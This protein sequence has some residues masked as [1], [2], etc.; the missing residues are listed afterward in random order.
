MVQLL[1]AGDIDRFELCDQPELST[2][3]PC[4]SALL[5]KRESFM[6]C[7]EGPKPSTGS[8]L[9]GRQSL[10][11]TC[12]P[13]SV[14]FWY[15]WV[16]G[17]IL[18]FPVTRCRN[19]WCQTVPGETDWEILFGFP[20]TS[21][22]WWL[23]LSVIYFFLIIYALEVILLQCRNRH[24]GKTSIPK[25]VP[26]GSDAHTHTHSCMYIYIYTICVYIYI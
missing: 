9:R 20:E 7:S 18:L 8:H 11:T 21:N 26:A 6:T 15:I 16:T 14:I 5:L 12:S 24:G 23:L 4:A 17:F 2:V 10:S 3:L 1:K 19:T 25:F 13:L 22:A